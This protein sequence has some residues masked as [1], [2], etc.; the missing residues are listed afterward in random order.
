M[1]PVSFCGAKRDLNPLIA[2]LDNILLPCYP[3]ITKGTKPKLRKM[4]AKSKAQARLMQAAC[5]SGE[6]AARVKIARPV[7]CEFIEEKSA[8]PANRRK[9][10]S[11]K[12]NAKT[13]PPGRTNCERSEAEANQ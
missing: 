6:F 13:R 2:P 3:T 8:K 7:A 12:P 1:L 11:V 10:E 9:G 5:H 4:P